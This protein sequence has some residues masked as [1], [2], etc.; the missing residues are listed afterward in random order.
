MSDARA[1]LACLA[2]DEVA[3]V[4]AHIV[5][6][7]RPTDELSLARQRKAVDALV[8]S[9]LV[10][11]SGKALTLRPA[12]IKAVLATL[13]ESSDRTADP[14]ARWIDADGRIAQYPRRGSDR[15]ELLQ[16]I[17]EQ[18]IKAGELVGEPELNAR[19]ERY[20]TDI[21]TLRRYLIV[22]GVFARESDGSVY[23]RP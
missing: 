7:G 14:M 3:R 6:H 9:G 1:M 20:T 10:A 12:E 5:L 21:P 15:T 2:N 16:K 18:T 11:R 23:W 19:L 4:F 8:R 17:G 22:H 13:A